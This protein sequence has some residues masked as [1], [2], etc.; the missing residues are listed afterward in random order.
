MSANPSIQAYNKLREQIP[1][2]DDV[3]DML[4]QLKSKD[5]HASDRAAAI[6]GATLIE[7]GLKV[8]MLSAF[9]ELGSTKSKALFDPDTPGPLG[10]FNDRIKVSYA[11]G[12]I[13]PKAQRDLVLVQKIRNL[14][15]HS[16]LKVSFKLTAVSDLCDQF[17]LIDKDDTRKPK[18]A[19]IETIAYIS[20]ALK[21]TISHEITVMMMGGAITMPRASRRFLP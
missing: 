4:G 14:F 13:G 9:V 2:H 17:V 20:E 7:H 19:Y 21:K 15:A 6:V 18:A 8:I 11:M 10:T 1:S 3:M 5:D 12:L 16:A